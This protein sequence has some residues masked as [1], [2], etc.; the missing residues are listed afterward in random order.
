MKKLLPLVLLVLFIGSCDK[1]SFTTEPVLEQILSGKEVAVHKGMLTFKDKVAF[2]KLSLELSKKDK[3]YILAWGKGLGF[4]SI[5]SIYEEAIEAEDIFLAEKVK[6]YGEN[7]EVIRDEM[8]FSTFTQ[9]YLDKGTLS[10][11]EE[12]ILDMNVMIPILAPLVNEDGLVRVG[13]ELRQYKYN[14]VKIILDADYNKIGD[15]K[16]LTESTDKVHVAAVERQQHEIKDVGR[17]KALASCESIMGS[18]RLI[19]Y[20]EKTLVNEGGTPC[21]VFRNDYYITQRSLKKI[22]GTWQNH[23]TEQMEMRQATA[24]LDHYNYDGSFNR[25]VYCELGGTYI[26][27][28]PYGHSYNYYLINNYDTGPCTNPVQG[29]EPYPGNLVFRSGTP[30]YFY[31]AGKNWTWCDIP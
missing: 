31:L 4:K 20:E 29:W 16:E 23:W 3:G 2:D 17:T 7:S 25:T 9:K 8:G 24:C 22:L 13:N 6:K 18:Y 14:V 11:T 26:R 5:Y 28:A 27:Y 15:L 1:E 30:K 12:G 21:S 19:A 10:H